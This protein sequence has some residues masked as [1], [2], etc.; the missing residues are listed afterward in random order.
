MTEAAKFYLLMML[1]HGSL[2]QLYLHN[3]SVSDSFLYCLSLTVQKLEQASTKLRDLPAYA[4]RIMDQ[5]HATP[6]LALNFLLTPFHKFS[7]EGCYPAVSCFLSLYSIYMR[8]F[9]D[10]FISL[11][12]RFSS[13]PLPELP[14][15]P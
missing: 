4:S 12:T 10:L 9:F 5:R 15:S 11:N 6:H 1:E 14:F 7:W 2:V 3:V 13:I 8:L